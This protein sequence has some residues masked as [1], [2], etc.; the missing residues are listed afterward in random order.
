MIPYNAKRLVKFPNWGGWVVTT[1]SFL[2]NTELNNFAWGANYT[3]PEPWTCLGNS[4]P[5]DASYTAPSAP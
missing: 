4:P 2:S 1:I 5:Y 3:L